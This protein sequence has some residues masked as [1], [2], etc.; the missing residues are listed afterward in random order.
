[1]TRVI[2]VLALWVA[3]VFSLVSVR[4]GMRGEQLVSAFQLVGAGIWVFVAWNT[5]RSYER[6]QRRLEGLAWY[7]IQSAG[8]LDNG[9]RVIKYDPD[10]EPD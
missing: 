8:V 3:L 6:L 4:S 2:P 10:Q 1:M 7:G 5:A 9:P